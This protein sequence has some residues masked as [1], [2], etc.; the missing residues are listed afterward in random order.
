M[1]AGNYFESSIFYERA[2]YEGAANDV[3]QHAVMG[4][5]NCLKKQEL[6]AEANTFVTS[7]FSLN[8]PDSVQTNLLYE[9]AV[10]SYLAGNFENT[11]SVVDQVAVA[12]PSYQH[13][14]FLKMLKILSY[15]ELQNW[16]AAKVEYK[17]W[18]ATYAVLDSA[19]QLYN[20]LPKL[21]SADRA[22]WLSTFIPGAG[23]IYAGKTWE[24]IASILLQGGSIYFGIRSWQEHYYISA[25][26][27]GLGLFGSFHNGGVRRAEVLVQQYNRKKVIAFNQTLKESLL[28]KLNSL[29]HK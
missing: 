17:N 19:D 16:S 15:N 2:L 25:W 4:K 5:L 23:Q 13:L 24:G 26:L 20:T 10:C 18:M 1:A 12:Y 6:Y 28:S 22:Q 3:W 21:K 9:Q 8:L 14:A 29:D 11:I 27:V 7:Y